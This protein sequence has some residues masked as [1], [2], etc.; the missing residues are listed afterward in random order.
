MTSINTIIING[1]TYN[2][3][4]KWRKSKT[5]NEKDK[6]GVLY[7]FPIEG[8]IW[9]AK[10]DFLKQLK[11][12]N[13][14]LKLLNKFSLYNNPKNCLLCKDK[15][16]ITGMFMYKNYI[17]EDG[18]IHYINIHNITPSKNFID[19]I[20][21]QNFDKT[22]PYLF[23][24]KG[25]VY[26]RDR[27]TYIQ[28]SRNQLNILDALMR[29]GGYTKK[30]V[31]NKKK[32]YRYS[33]HMG[34]LDFDKNKLYKII[35]SGETTRVDKNDTEIYFPNNLH[36]L[37]DYEYI[38]HT[39]PPTPKP[40]G[41][42]KEGILYEFPSI[43]DILHF[44]YYHNIGHT[45]GSLVV[46][47]EGLY[48]IRKLYFDNK[49]IKINENILFKNYGDVFIEIQDNALKLYGSDFTTHYFYSEIAQNKTFID[50]LNELLNEF[51]I[52]I[53]FFP[54]KEDDK[55]SWIL[56][57]IYLPVYNNKIVSK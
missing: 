42:A 18:L 39:H 48:N 41:R 12:V 35:I 28:I 11:Y 4:S 45:V 36:D 57:T 26:E 34:V 20:Y 25:I 24:Y 50:K 47:P 7:P 44:I 51:Q 17:W 27:L 43:G 6:L 55:K 14:H 16:V 53:D 37:P 13:K 8:N 21:S 15:N 30:Y 56:D 52:H 49:K 46:T 2:V 33:E 29:H 31:D 38:F 40:G 22:K 32:I 9:S 1:S 10:Y 3:E 54:R 19:F 23:R 5:S